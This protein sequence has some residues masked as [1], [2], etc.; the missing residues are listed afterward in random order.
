MNVSFSLD[1]KP[2]SGNRRLIPARGRW[3]A[4][5]KYAAYKTYVWA[6]AMKAMNRRI[7]TVRSCEVTITLGPACKRMDLDSPAKV[8]LDGMQGAIYAN[9]KQVVS[10]T[11]TR[12]SNPA[13]PPV[14][15]MVGERMIP[16]RRN[17]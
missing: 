9:D 17:P 14:H 10:L 5:P 15:I 11:L 13:A 2:V 3:I 1:R 7:W 16:E 12:S 8:L 4:D 6:M